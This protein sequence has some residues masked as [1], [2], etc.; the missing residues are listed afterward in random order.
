MDWDKPSLQ[1]LIVRRLIK[2]ENVIEYYGINKNDVLSSAAKQAELFNRVFPDQVE[3]GEKQSTTIDWLLK[4]TS[5][6]SN[7]TQ[8]RDII[9]FLNSLCEVQNQRLERGE[10]QP[11]GE[12]LFDRTS[13]KDAL[14]ALSEYRVVRV[15]Y[16]EY[17]NLRQYVDALKEQKTEQNAES[18]CSL[19]GCGCNCGAG[20]ARQLRDIG[21]F[22]ERTSKGETTYWVPFVYRPYLDMSQGKERVFTDLKAK[23]AASLIVS[24]NAPKDKISPTRLG[25]RP[26]HPPRAD[27]GGGR[28][29]AA[30]PR[31][32]GEALRA[33]LPPGPQPR[34]PGRRGGRPP[35][36]PR[37]IWCGGPESVRTVDCDH[38]P[39]RQ[40]TV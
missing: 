39:L 18:A 32:K 34:P 33:P 36:G 15:L 19:M 21:F 2:N 14:P 38:E 12:F 31:N 37:P 5:D 28:E 8:P 22:E 3:V 6:A 10:P 7:S 30:A 26:R 23:Q 27:A 24:A 1:N 29:Q 11:E 25:L 4:R 13:F 20:I 17:P 9:L 35:P 40:P 16:A